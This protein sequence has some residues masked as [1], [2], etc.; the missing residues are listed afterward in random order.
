MAKLGGDRDRA[1]QGGEQHSEQLSAAEHRQL[2]GAAAEVV[3]G[4]REGVQQDGQEGERE[5]PREQ[6]EAGADRALLQQ[7][8]AKLGPHDAALAVSSR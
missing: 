6:T 4:Q 7:L 2:V 8:G 1:E 5:H 3:G